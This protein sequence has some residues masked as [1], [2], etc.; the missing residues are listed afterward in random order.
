MK[1][2]ISM[3]LALMMM[4]SICAVQVSAEDTQAS[5]NLVYY[6]L[7]EQELSST[8]GY[9]S[10]AQWSNGKS[11]YDTNAGGFVSR[12]TWC[13]A[14]VKTGKI[15]QLQSTES[16]GNYRLNFYGLRTAYLKEG[17]YS[18]PLRKVTMG[19][20]TSAA[21]E[22]LYDTPVKLWFNLYAVSAEGLKTLV[23]KGFTM[24]AALL[25]EVNELDNDT[26]VLFFC[27][28]KASYR[29]LYWNSALAETGTVFGGKLSPICSVGTVGQSDYVD[30]EYIYE[31]KSDGTVVVKGIKVEDLARTTLIDDATPIS[32]LEYKETAGSEFH[33]CSLRPD[34]TSTATK[35]AVAMII[36]PTTKVND[37]VKK[38]TLTFN[39][40][41]YEGLREIE[42][43]ATDTKIVD[44]EQAQA[45]ISL[46]NHP[47]TEL[48]G[49]AIFAVYDGDK[50]I[51]VDIDKNVY[52]EA[53]AGSTYNNLLKVTNDAFADTSKTFTYKVFLL[54]A[55]DTLVPITGE[56]SGDL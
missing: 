39:A 20:K 23:S 29:S 55:M 16:D 35:N 18:V 49:T 46:T 47:G 32:G 50:L 8:N 26:L 10:N 53:S 17:D 41:K 3:A 22:S 1:K 24:D 31:P 42:F 15:L 25:S 34:Y 12:D 21:V 4:L 36:V 28:V 30:I 44:N 11:G 5:T 37:V 54:E 56:L 38:T 27:D 7:Q 48:S 43:T 2:I 14:H 40:L 19:F 9:T 13:R 6:D 51:G 45:V 33:A 52:A